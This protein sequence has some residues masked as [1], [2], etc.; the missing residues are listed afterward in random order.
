MTFLKAA[1]AG[2][3]FALGALTTAAQAAVTL[4]TDDAGYSGP[5]IDLSAYANGQYNF[6]FGPITLPGGITLTAAPG[7]GGNS[8]N[9]SVVGQ[10]DY[11]LASNGS[12]GGDATYIGVDSRT[13][14]VELA[15]DTAVSSFGAYFNYAPGF[16]D[17]P[18]LEAFDD[19]G[20]L[21]ASFDLE[22]LAPIRTPGGFNE[23]E[24]RGLVS[25]VAN[26]AR[27]RF[28]GSFLL[29]AGSPDGSLATMNPV[30]IP[31]ALPLF[32]GAIGAGSLV[33]RRRRAN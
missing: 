3:V 5:V 8:G 7:G 10:G 25:D 9:G 23:F 20:M 11:G 14:F 28:G 22:E 32:V 26:I 1:A 12:F 15:F 4:V 31:A 27:I 18:T 21:I 29:L 13:G 16:G 33:R 6:T 17:A 2:A 30:P 19:M 24:F